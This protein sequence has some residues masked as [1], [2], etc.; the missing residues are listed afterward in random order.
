M[1]LE[2]TSQMQSRVL[3]ATLPV[4]DSILQDDTGILA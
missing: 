1:N 2:I 4:N 3:L